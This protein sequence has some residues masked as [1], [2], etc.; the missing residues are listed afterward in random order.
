M[1]DGE[2]CGSIGFRWQPGTTDL[3]RHVLGHIGYSVVPWKRRLGYA[4]RGARGSS[5]PTPPPRVWRTS[6]SR[7]TSTTSG[8]NA[9]IEANGGVIRR[10]VR[11]RPGVRRRV[12]TPLPHQPPPRRARR[13]R[14]DLAAVDR[15]PVAGLEVRAQ[16]IGDHRAVH[17]RSSGAATRRGRGTRARRSSPPTGAARRR[18]SVGRARRGRTGARARPDASSTSG[19]NSVG[20]PY[21]PAAITRSWSAFTSSLVVGSA[22]ASS[23]IAGSS[24]SLLQQVPGDVGIVRLVP[25]LVQRPRRSFVPAVEVIHAR[26]PQQRTDAHHR[27]AVRPLPFPRVLLALDPVDLLQAEELPRDVESVLRPHVPDPLRRLIG[28]RTH[29]VEVEVDP[30]D[31]RRARLGSPSPQPST[32]SNPRLCRGFRDPSRK[33]R[34]KREMTSGRGGRGWGGGVCGSGGRGGSGRRR[35]SR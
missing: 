30:R 5:C 34:R 9:S 3:P 22:I 31:R 23:T 35:R 4:T 13:E 14:D 15:H 24:P 20:T 7:P 10:R 12:Q 11:T 16:P 8:R 29:H 25:F 2:F 6:S 1:W 33:P 19:K 18:P 32:R 17:A 28:E 27:P 21:P 26:P